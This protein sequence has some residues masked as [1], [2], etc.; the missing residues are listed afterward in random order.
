MHL[1]TNHSFQDRESTDIGHVVIGIA[2][3]PSWQYHI[4][5]APSW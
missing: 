2:K 4:A 1:V 3:T 5:K